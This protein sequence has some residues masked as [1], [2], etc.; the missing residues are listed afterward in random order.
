M[1]DVSVIR[2]ALKVR[3]QTIAGL[4]CYD[5]MPQKPEVPAA[6]VSLHTAD[7][8]QD[9]DSNTKYTFYIWIY[10]SGADIERAQRRLDAYLAPSGASSVKAAIEADQSLDGIADWAHVTGWTQGVQVVP[11]YGSQ[12]CALPL[13]C[14]VMAS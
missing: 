4:N 13:D 12:V 5:V 9:M 14:E 8:D 11:E 10:V 1:A 3:L 2:A 6:A 7:F